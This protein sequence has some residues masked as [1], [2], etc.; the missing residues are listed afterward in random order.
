MAGG[1]GDYTRIDGKL[2]T[3]GL[4]AGRKTWL[5]LSRGGKG[6]QENRENRTFGGPGTQQLL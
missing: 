3:M 5:Q 4:G 1:A 2:I 6:F